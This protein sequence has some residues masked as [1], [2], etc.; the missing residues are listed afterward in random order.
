MLRKTLKMLRKTPRKAVAQL[1][2]RTVLQR[3]AIGNIQTKVKLAYLTISALGVRLT[4]MLLRN[5]NFC[6]ASS[7]PSSNYS[8]QSSSI[9]R[10]LLLKMFPSPIGLHCH[11]WVRVAFVTILSVSPTFTNLIV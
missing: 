1:T 2:T 11:S 7:K 3:V 8:N 4:A 6:I 5:T 9:P 10:L